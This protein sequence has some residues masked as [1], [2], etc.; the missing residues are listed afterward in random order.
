MKTLRV[1]LIGLG[2]VGSQVLALLQSETIMAR[3]GVRFDVTEVAVK[4][5][6][7]TRSGIL[8]SMTLHDD[9]MRLARSEKVD[10]VIELM[11]GEDEAAEVIQAA[12]SLKKS[13]ITANKAALA[14]WGKSLFALSQKNEVP[15]AFE[16]AV[17]GGIPVIKVLNEG[18]A[19]NDIH[20]V[21]GILNGTSNYV[22]SCMT[23]QDQ[24]FE[25][26]LKQ[27]Q[28]EGYAEAD[29]SRD[30]DGDDVLDKIKILANLAF[31]FFE[32]DP[33]IATEGIRHIQITDIREAK[34]LGFVFK[35]LAYAKKI[36]DKVWLA[37][38]P[39]LVPDY[40]VLSRVNGAM[41]A[42]YLEANQTGPML[43]YGKGAGGAPT[44]SAVLA[45][46]IDIVK[47]Q[48]NRFFI[49]EK[50]A[51]LL[52]SGSVSHAYYLRLQGRHRPGTIASITQVLAKYQISIE[53]I[54]QRHQAATPQSLPIVIITH[55][56]TEQ[57]LKQ[58]ILCLN[59]L[60][61]IVD[62]VV[63]FPLLKISETKEDAFYVD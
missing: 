4:N 39:T 17:A 62:P 9:P 60:P 31:G 28:A 29:P 26:A 5:L 41:N 6:Q 48:K 56:I 50:P 15:F 11:G 55:A 21:I 22:L 57:T 1:G 3:A 42:V 37:V 47:G 34:A 38:R 51:E 19:A 54:T 35:L 40:H 2:T 46:L 58:A 10:V 20:S 7:K 13:V 63:A 27:A 16:A 30:I 33:T 24:S 44:A 45:D 8:P 49:A 36:E 23:E 59:Q 25:T 43:L 12:L 52:A 53:S 61:E 18:L 32:N 14:K